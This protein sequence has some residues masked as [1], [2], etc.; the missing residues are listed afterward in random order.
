MIFW[1]DYRSWKRQWEMKPFNEVWSKT[2][3]DAGYLIL[4]TGCLILDLVEGCEGNRGKL[5]GSGEAR[6]G[7]F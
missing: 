3:L 1:S 4:D 2:G 5:G 6:D 7:E